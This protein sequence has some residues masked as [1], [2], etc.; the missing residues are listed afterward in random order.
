MSKKDITSLVQRL[1]T[2]EERLGVRIEGLSAF[3]STEVFDGEVDIKVRGELHA[4]SGTNLE[5]DISLELS[6]HDAEGQVIQTGSDYI[7]SE[8][9]FGFQTFESPSDKHLKS[10]SSDLKK[11]MTSDS[12]TR[13]KYA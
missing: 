13:P 6:V 4:A 12:F 9:F 7:V 1:E 5:Q 11:S 3:E 10:S 8:S 2:F